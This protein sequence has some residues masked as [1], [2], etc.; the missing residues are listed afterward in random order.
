MPLRPGQPVVEPLDEKRMEP[1]EDVE[2]Q[3]GDEKE[4]PR[5][6][7]VEREQ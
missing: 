6:E 7:Q 5:E 4:E 3:R 1:L 2:W